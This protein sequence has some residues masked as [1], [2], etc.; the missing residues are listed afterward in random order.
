MLNDIQ[1]NINLFE[2]DWWSGHR[3]TY[4]HLKGKKR[5]S[6]FFTHESLGHTVSLLFEQCFFIAQVAQ[7]AEEQNLKG[8]LCPDC[9]MVHPVIWQTCN[10]CC[11]GHMEP[12][13]LNMA[14]QR[15]SYCHCWTASDCVSRAGMC[16]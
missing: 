4:A 8:Y 12:A 16:G 7:T 14:Y 6:K 10:R 5:R 3:S 1:L 11:K 9:S 2:H 13:T 15:F